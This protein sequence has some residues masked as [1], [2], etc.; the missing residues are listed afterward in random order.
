[1]I[2][3]TI[4][5]EKISNLPPKA[6]PNPLSNMPYFNITEIKHIV[7]DYLPNASDNQIEDIT[8]LVVKNMELIL[9]S[10]IRMYAAKVKAG[11]LDEIL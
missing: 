3:L 10:E 6:N 2:Y 7:S 9:F 5:L 4:V 11:K 8:G 1:M